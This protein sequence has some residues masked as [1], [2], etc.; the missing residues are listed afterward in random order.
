MS[1]LDTKLPSKIK[2]LVKQGALFFV[3]HSAGKDSQAM[4]L[5]VTKHV[6]H[7]QIIVIHSDLGKA[8]WA[9]VQSHIKATINHRLNVVTNSKRDFF[10]MVR[11]RGMFPSPKFRQCTSGLKVQPINV[12]IRR[13]MKEHD[14][15]IGL[16]LTGIRAEESPNRKKKVD[17]M[18]A[19]TGTAMDYNKNL[20]IFNRFD[21]PEGKT[22]SKGRVKRLQD[23]NS[24]KDG[25]RLVFDWLPIFD[26]TTV[27]VF[28]AIKDSGQLPHWA[29]L[30]GMS[31]LSCAFCIMARKSDLKISA[32]NN[33]ELLKEYVALEK[34]VGH[35]MFMSKG[36]PIALDEYIGDYENHQ[37]PNLFEMCTVETSGQE[38]A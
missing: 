30:K 23:F 2:T 33:P 22:D 25:E 26:W 10:G 19:K 8:E 11:E 13:I 32:Q 18:V 29:Y 21:C 17:A 28:Q 35:T 1:K 38:V 34:E 27:D 7:D 4:Y 24:P 5:Y 12:L 36:A 6:P 15:L 20:T 14:C 9:G 3:S 16:N 37:A 31:R